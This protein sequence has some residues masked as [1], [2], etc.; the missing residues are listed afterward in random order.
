MENKCMVNIEKIGNHDGRL[1]SIENE[2]KKDAEVKERI[3][4]KIDKTTVKINNINLEIASL[5]SSFDGFKL[6]IEDDIKSFKN[7]IESGFE[8]FKTDMKSYFNS[9]FMRS[10]IVLVVVLIVTKI[11]DKVFK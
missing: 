10:G 5:R 7:N 6:S 11:L 2:F 4:D 9:I 1:T 3:F 8:A